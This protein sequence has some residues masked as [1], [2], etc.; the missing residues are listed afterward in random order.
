MD[1]APD[2][3]WH[4]KNFIASLVLLAPILRTAAQDGVSSASL[5][6]EPICGFQAKHF[7]LN[8]DAIK[9]GV[10]VDLLVGDLQIRTPVT[11]RFLVSQKPRGFPLDELQVEHEKLIHVIGVRDDLQEFF[12]VHPVKIDSGLW[13]VDH[14]FTNGGNYQV[15]SDVKYR[16]VSYSFAHPRLVVAEGQGEK[17]RKVD[18]KD[19]GSDSGYE[20][21]FNHS[22]PLSVV[23][24]NRL[25]F[26][27]HDAAGNP[28]A[29]DNFLGAAMHLVIVSKDLSVFLHAHPENHNVV[30]TNVYFSQMF[31]EKGVYKLFLQYRP[32]TANLGRDEALL[33]EFYV[34][35]AGAESR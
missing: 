33:A 21:R 30:T 4:L 14:V 15:W 31:P 6:K 9:Q 10:S 1:Q 34:N 32:S 23:K 29:T 27:I 3:T 7:Y 35:V 13:G 20:V 11:L 24:T 25:Q 16:G 12:H 22:E 28:V 2:G 19:R 17:A 8:A 26:A 5:V 18:R